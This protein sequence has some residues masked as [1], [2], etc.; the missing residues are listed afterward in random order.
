MNSQYPVFTIKNECQDC[1][2]CVRSCPVKAI[3]ISDG[4][5]SVISENCIA[6][7]QCISVCPQKAKK[8][9][10]DISLVHEMLCSDKKVYA[11][12]APS[13]RAALP[14]SIKQLI[15]ALKEIGFADVYET[16]LGAQEISIQTT[17][18]LRRREKNLWISSACPVIVD[19]ITMYLP[20]FSQYIIPLTSPAVTHG[21]MLKD[22]FGKDIHMVFIGP[23]VAKKNEADQFPDLMEAAIGFN[24]LLEMLKEHRI[25]LKSKPDEES[26]QFSDSAYEGTLYPMEGGMNETIHLSGRAEGIKLINVS[27]IQMICNQ[28]EGLDPDSITEPIFI[29]AMACRGGC[30]NGPL[31]TGNDPGLTA[32]SKTLK[33]VRYRKKIPAA[34]QTILEHHYLPAVVIDKTPSPELI[35]R[36]ML[37]IG[38]SSIEDELNCEGCGYNTCHDLAIAI[39]N[40]RAEP[41]MCI[42]Y[43]RKIAAR[44]AGAVF[45]SMPSGILMV[46]RNLKIL[47]TNKSF[48]RMFAAD[49]YEGY[50]NDPDCLNDARLEKVIPCTELFESALE[51]NMDIHKEHY[52]MNNGL[53]EISIFTVEP[54]HI[55]G[56]V[57]ADVTEYEMRR[58]QIAKKAHS[59]IAKNI[60]IVQEIACSLGEHMVETE[61]LL[62]S[63][64]EG[65]DPENAEI[66]KQERIEEENSIMSNLAALY[67]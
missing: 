49:L 43:M 45:N 30:L 10:S 15:K 54:H 29:E 14:G 63:I 40:Q 28:L 48:V 27:T 2:R 41:H 21:Q 35:R 59:V 61:L 53:F 55:V 9:R 47:E 26:M 31:I 65:Y 56:A 58:D 25:E 19:Y 64:A 23:C 50:D 8:V 1:Y 60:A 5:A 52:P 33:S 57:I 3:R 37:R 66:S 11:S 4:H 62:T 16:A 7:G 6:C 44:K 12:L 46:D 67:E 22:Q 24:E 32:I 18:I 39:I 17:E 34:V 36:A 38:K 51:T 13:W 42:S 20:Q